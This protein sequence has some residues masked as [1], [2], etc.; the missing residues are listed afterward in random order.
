[1]RTVV[2]T[3]ALVALFIA[4]NP[5]ALAAT[6]PETV[7]LTPQFLTAGANVQRL[8]VY[9]IADIVII[10]GRA[11]D[12]DQ[13]AILSQRAA[14][15]GYTRVAN[16]IQTVEHADADITRRAEREL[17]IHR[18]LDGCRFNVKSDD[19]VVRV[20]GTVRHELQKDV[21]V[22]V[23]RSVPGVRSVEINLQRF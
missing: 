10:R 19:G 4:L 23:L 6:Q 20:A 15:L 17:T 9:Q 12:K 1:M 21:A 3:A 8:Q 14:L 11:A 22:Q 13:A 7:D 18:A 2:K 16:L 5:V